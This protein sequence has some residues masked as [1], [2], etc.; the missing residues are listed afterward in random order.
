MLFCVTVVIDVALDINAI[1]TSVGF[2]RML[3]KEGGNP[4]TLA[5][6]TIF[7]V[8]HMSS[9]RMRLSLL[10]RGTGHFPHVGHSDEETYA[11]NS[12]LGGKVAK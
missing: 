10:V 9:S 2:D 5:M 7:G 11:K 8:S 3:G 4:I 12:C 6:I 1:Y